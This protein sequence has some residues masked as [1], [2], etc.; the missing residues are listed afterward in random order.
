MEQ[1]VLNNRIRYMHTLYVSYFEQRLRGR[2]QRVTAYQR[3]MYIRNAYIMSAY[4]RASVR[5][6]YCIHDVGRR[7]E[8]KREEREKEREREREREK[9]RRGKASLIGRW[10]DG[11]LQ[12]SWGYMNP[13]CMRFSLHH[14]LSRSSL[15]FFPSLV[16]SL[17]LLF[18]SRLP[19]LRFYPVVKRRRVTWTQERSILV[20][21]PDLVSLILSH[22]FS[23][24]LSLSL[25]F[26]F[27]HFFFLSHTHFVSL[28]S[29]FY[30]AYLSISL[31][32]STSIFT[33]VFV[34]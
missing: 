13:A 14:F 23:L 11:T 4:V 31:T 19:S 10:H 17:S 33:P 6:S 27:I 9:E 7:N 1:A 24:S 32:V 3:H 16:L 15:F 8:R 21:Q 5:R 20:P 18:V 30:F 26:S 29:Y 2:P 12:L 22:S 28:V 34:L 25:T